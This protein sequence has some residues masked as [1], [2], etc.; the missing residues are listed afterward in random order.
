MHDRTQPDLA[1]GVG[2][3][4]LAIV[5]AYLLGEAGAG[6]RGW[7]LVDAGLAGSAGA[8]ARAA[9]DRFGA[10]ARPNA[11]VLTHAHFDH[12]GALRALARRWGAPVFAHPL[13]LGYL[14]GRSDYPP[15]DPSV[16]GGLMASLSFAFPRRG[17]KLDAQV[18]PLPADGTLP[19]LDGW[20]WLPTP[21]HA[22]GHVSLFREADRTLIAG[23]AVVTTRQESARAALGR[24][25][26]LHG[27]PAYFT[28][29]WESAR[30]S[31]RLLAS[32]EPELLLTGHGRP[33]RG[34]GM[35]RAL[36]ALAEDFDARHV[37]R[38][39][40]YVGRPARF[41][42]TGAVQSVPPPTR[43]AALP[44]VGAILAGTAAALALRARRQ[45]A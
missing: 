31:A 18:R 28:P 3:V 13:E 20:R 19:G 30:E 40:R 37:P 4:E 29:D 2:V 22:P 6:D 12:V 15:P 44:I 8:I 36:H 5:N 41:D 23:D 45:R 14:E 7:I 27:P 21:G 11:I 25:V 16:G 35:R 24:P 9:A 32:L 1:P 33:M 26:E 43:V 10:A 34:P 38:R 39:G 42:A 17:M